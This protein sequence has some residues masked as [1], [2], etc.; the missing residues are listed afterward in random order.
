MSDIDEIVTHPP[1]APR[2]IRDI[3]W[4]A[5]IVEGEGCLFYRNGVSLRV[6][7]TDKDVIEKFADIVGGNVRGGNISPSRLGH[8]RKPYWHVTLYGKHAVAWMMTIYTLLGSR[9]QKKAEELI[10]LWKQMPGYRWR[11]G[12]HTTRIIPKCH[13]EK[14]HKAFGFCEAC[15]KRQ[16]SSEQQNGTQ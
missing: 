6:A 3:A 2:T 8:P 16:W 11:L 1:R 12:L 14:K 4:V 7:M 15:Y 5:G 9:R 10:A 13:P